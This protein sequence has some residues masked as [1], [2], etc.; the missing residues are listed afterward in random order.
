MSI[1]M[2]NACKVLFLTLG[3]SLASLPVAADQNLT[4][5]ELFTSQGCSSC[6]PADKFL[7]DLAERG[8]VL[9]LS[10]HVDYWD[11]IGWKDPFAKPVHTTRQRSYAGRFGLSYVYTPQM[12][13]HGA[14]QAVGSDRSAV[15]TRIKQLQKTLRVPVSLSR[16]GNNV[17]V[18]LPDLPSEHAAPESEVWMVVFDKKHVTPV[19][20]GENEGR[21]ID[22]FNVVRNLV[23]IGTWNG[24]AGKMTAALPD[25]ITKA[26]N[27][28]A[29]IV[30]ASGTGRILGA[31]RM[32]LK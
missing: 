23:R 3:L 29:V 12:V 10:Y 4:V 17:V 11:Y 2:K 20:R 30:Q 7:G 27:G 24:K 1:G 28:C 14:A 19:K 13:V 32:A 5:V 25:G 22:N 15:N 9:A 18:N 31:A 26:K 16:Q 6:P 8:D 21:T